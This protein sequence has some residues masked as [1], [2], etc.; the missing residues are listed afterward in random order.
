MLFVS[1][2]FKQ[3]EK[4]NII[5]SVIAQYEAGMVCMIVVSR[6]SDLWKFLLFSS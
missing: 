1:L 6:K 3:L 5:V 4:L 2:N